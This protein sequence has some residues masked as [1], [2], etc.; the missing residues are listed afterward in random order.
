MRPVPST[1]DD[2]F[3]WTTNYRNCYKSYEEVNKYN[4]S[5][6]TCSNIQGP[7]L[8]II[9]PIRHSLE[10]F[11]DKAR[12][13]TRQ[14]FPLPPSTH[15]SRTPSETGTHPIFASSSHHLQ[16]SR[17]KTAVLPEIRLSPEKGCRHQALFVLSLPSQAGG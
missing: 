5:P 16:L 15:P 4:P 13:H 3:N 6:P 1:W 17:P 14:P 12:D 11:Q 7:Y 9:D 10:V 8:G 2:A